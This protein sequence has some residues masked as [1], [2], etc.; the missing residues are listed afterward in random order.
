MFCG[1]CGTD[2]PDTNRFCKNCGKPVNEILQQ[3]AP[4][5]VPAGPKPGRTKTWIIIGAIIAVVILAGTGVLLQSGFMTIGL[6]LPALPAVGTAPGPFPGSAAPPAAQVKEPVHGTVTS[7]VMAPA[8]QGSVSAAGGTITVNQPGSAINGLLF[9]APAGAYPSGQQVTISSAPITAHTFGSNFNPA[10]P[11]IAINAGGTYADEPV[12]VTIPVTIPDDQFAMAFYYDDAN[13]KLEGIPTANQDSKSI[14]IATRHFSN[15]LVSMISLSSLNGITKVDSG[16]RPGVD[17]WEF[18]NDGSYIAP[19]GYCAGQSATMMW[20]YTEQRQKN[21]AAPGLYGLYDNNGREKTPLFP[22]DNTRG[23]R[24]ASVIQKV[25]DQ[26]KYWDNSDFFSNISDSTTFREF[27]YSMLVTGEPQYVSIRRDGGGHAIVCYEVSDTTLWIADPNF[28][29][30]ER[31]ITLNGTTLSPYTSGANSQDIK[32]NGVRIYP[33]IRYVAKSALFSWPALAAEYAKV[34]DGTIG[35]DQ[36]R[37]YAAVIFAINDDGSQTEAGRI[38]A[39]GKNTGVTRINV[40]TKTVQIRVVNPATGATFSYQDGRPVQN[41]ITLIEG[42]N[43][44]AVEGVRRDVN[45]EWYGFDWID[46]VYTPPVTPAAPSAGH[47]VAYLY[48]VLPSMEND[49]LCN[50]YYFYSDDPAC[51]SAKWTGMNTYCGKLPEKC[52]DYS[53]KGGIAEEITYTGTQDR[54]TIHRI[55]DGY[56]RNFGKNGVTI[57][58]TNYEN[59]VMTENCG[60]SSKKAL[61]TYECEVTGD[62]NLHYTNTL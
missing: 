41:P 31:M 37:P 22:T 45:E 16:F 24:F 59:G 28:P 49:P 9:T 27:K 21:P 54:D 18:V 56:T 29:G 48:A 11:L 39:G 2:N 57:H 25:T 51:G 42:S 15:I 35:D 61:G 14:T 17:D 23:I 33:R 20:Y 44:I 40:G 58:R 4:A 6:T 55:F 13:K 38:A 43:I 46:L 3:P 50:H 32:E 53:Y 36:F 62:T 47:Y 26:Q 12:L 60:S 30:K 7:G 5:P 52:I 1:E 34:Q 19:G 8:A 10:T